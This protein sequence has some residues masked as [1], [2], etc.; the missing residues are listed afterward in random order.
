VE[1]REATSP[2]TLA[3]ASTEELR[4]R[5]LLRSLFEPGR[6]RL[7]YSHEDRL[8]VGGAVPTGQ[9][10]RLEPE[11]PLRARHFLEN[12]EAGILHV[13][14]G[15]GVVTVDGQR[16]ELAP[17]DILFVGRGAE[18][19]ELE[20]ASGTDPSRLYVVSAVAHRAFP[21]V[22]IR[23]D[24]VSP[25]ELGSP[26]RASLRDLRRYVPPDV[27]QSAAL[28]MGVTTLHPG[29]VWNTMPAHT[30]DRRTEVYL[31][32]DLPED[33]RVVHLMGAPEE[34]RTLVVANEEAVISPPWSIHSG[35]GTAS[36]RFCWAMA[37]ENTDYDDMDPV[38]P[39]GLR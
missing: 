37:G 34:T 11:D 9:R 25:V 14:G 27:G 7:V 22:Q 23:E 26:D 31:Y 5:Y 21:T 10:L 24:D 6:L 39:S 18:E 13:G 30:H 29:S 12:R 19:V 16:Y 15:P 4:R 32:F 33:D 17:R 20:S 8:I 1:V 3:G 36:Y 38:P 28:M 35:V 2:E